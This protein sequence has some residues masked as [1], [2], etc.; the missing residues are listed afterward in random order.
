M[1]EFHKSLW[2]H[3]CLLNESDSCKA[4]KAGWFNCYLFDLSEDCKRSGHCGWDVR[5]AASWPLLAAKVDLLVAGAYSAQ[6]LEVDA[7][8][9]KE[10]ISW[11]DQSIR[12]SN[13]GESN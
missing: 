3:Q 13:E 5:R 7:I 10:Q 1:A 4:R 11:L 12:H 9:G 2:A 6:E 8:S